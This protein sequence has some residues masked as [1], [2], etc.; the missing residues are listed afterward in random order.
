[1]IKE[2]IAKIFRIKQ[3]VTV[4]PSNQQEL[5]RAV[6]YERGRLLGESLK[7]K[8]RAEELANELNQVQSENFKESANRLNQKKED[9]SKENLTGGCDWRA[10]FEEMGKMRKKKK[11]RVVSFDMDREFGIFDRIVTDVRGMI[12]LYVKD[13]DTIKRVISG[14]KFSSIFRFPYGISKM[15]NRGIFIVNLNKEGE[16]VSDPLHAEIPDLVEDANGKYDLSQVDSE[17][18]IDR[19]V[20]VQSELVD[21]HSRIE[22]LEKT[23]A[24]KIR[25]ENLVRHQ[26]NVAKARADTSESELSSNIQ[27]ITEMNQS[28]SSAVGRI[29]SLSQQVDIMTK[30]NERYEE[31]MDKISGKLLEMKE[32]TGMEHAKDL[33]EDTMEIIDKFRPSS[34]TVNVES[35]SSNFDENM[36]KLA[37]QGKNIP[38]V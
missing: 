9:M 26:L 32:K 37:Q 28:Y 1:M 33:M 20:K 36:K 21:A 30:Q 13:K 38:K 27:K 18:F 11:I 29:S 4:T 34:Q 10:L 5:D 23:M 31:G 25:K 14:S 16:H 7:E 6:D 22:T 17:P 12:H 2:L 3:N 24:E 15:A 35:N 19:Y 8:K